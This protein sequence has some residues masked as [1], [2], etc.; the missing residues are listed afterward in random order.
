MGADKVYLAAAPELVSMFS[1][2]D[3]VDKVILRNQAHTVQHDYWVPGFSAGWLSGNTFENFENDPFLK[4]IPESVT[5]WK[6]IINSDKIKVGIRW[7][8]NPKFEHQQFRRFPPKFITNLAK[9]SELQIYSLQRDHNLVNLPEN[10]VDLQHLLISWEDTMAAIEN[11]DIVI[12]SCTSIAHLAASMG[13]ETWVIVPILPYHTWTVGAP[14]STTSPYYK[15][16]RIFRQTDHKTWNSTFQDLYSALEKKFNLQKVEHTNEDR[17]TKRLNLGCGTF[18]FEGF[19]NVD[20]SKI[21]NPDEVVDLDI[22]P[23]KWEDDE[24]DHIVA[25]DILE[26]LGE[27]PQDLIKYIKEMYRVTTNGGIWEVVVPHW[28]CDIALDD[29]THKRLITKTMF[30]LFNKKALYEGVA[31][32]RSE[33]LIAFEEDI[34]IEICDVQFEYTEPYKKRIMAGTISEEELNYSLNHLNNVAYSMRLLIQVHKPGRYDTKEIEDLIDNIQKA[35]P[36]K[37]NID[38]PMAIPFSK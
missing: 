20:K 1:R 27:K 14:E 12:T 25:K 16:V 6:N 9:Y 11:L 35:N 3:S 34:D 5:V 19:L 22:T 30:N 26:H 37:L 2:M 32:G 24:F 23:W 38:S 15:C 36:T 17:V 4:A 21:V 13:K 28:R 10:V 29:L 18:K 33:S 7:A 8:G 31:A